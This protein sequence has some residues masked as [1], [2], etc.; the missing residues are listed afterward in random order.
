MLFLTRL[1]RQSR[2]LILRL[3]WINLPLV[4]Q[5]LISTYGRG[6]MV[7]KTLQPIW[8]NNKAMHPLSSLSPNAV[9]SWQKH[10]L[11]WEDPSVQWLVLSFYNGLRVG[12][13]RR[14][15]QNLNFWGQDGLTR[16]GYY[17]LSL[18]AACLSTEQQDGQR[19]ELAFSAVVLVKVNTANC[20]WAPVGSEGTRRNNWREPMSCSVS[21]IQLDCAGPLHN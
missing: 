18:R 3:L 6:H 9:G 5:P 10:L 14:E 7:F 1:E 2:Y 11:L 21:Y 17:E 13:I 19:K 15:K 12:P 16:L 8:L 4:R 20:P